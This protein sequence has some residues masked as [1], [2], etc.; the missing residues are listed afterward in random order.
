MTQGTFLIY[1]VNIVISF[2]LVKK[3]INGYTWLGLEAAKCIRV[4][5]KATIL[6]YWQFVSKSKYYAFKNRGMMV[7]LYYSP[8]SLR[9]GGNA[10]GF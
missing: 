6:F 10:I 2:F 1:T 5:N 4:F 7:L 9:P 8:L 3:R